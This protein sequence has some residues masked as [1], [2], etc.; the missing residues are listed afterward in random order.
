MKCP[1]CKHH[2]EPHL[3]WRSILTIFALT[4]LIFF[5]GG[6]FFYHEFLVPKFEQRI[7]RDGEIKKD[8]QRGY[9]PPKD[10]KEKIRK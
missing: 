5:I 6:L 2:I 1:I 3:D 10:L 8:L 9:V 4:G 7:E